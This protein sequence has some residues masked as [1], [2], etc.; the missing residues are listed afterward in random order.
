[1][2]KIQCPKPVGKRFMHVP[3]IAIIILMNS[4]TII[5][6]NNHK[7]RDAV[8]ILTTYNKAFE[9][10]HTRAGELN[11][12]FDQNLISQMNMHQAL[13]NDISKTYRF[14]SIENIYLEKYGQHAYNELQLKIS[15]NFDRKMRW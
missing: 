12:Y 9:E 1:M 8:E 4:L 15:D 3:L 10:F 6:C 5:S 13:W 11:S 14:D 7:D 2:R